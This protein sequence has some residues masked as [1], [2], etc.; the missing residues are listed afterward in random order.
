MKH[1]PGNAKESADSKRLA[2]DVRTYA[3][4]G[5]RAMFR[6]LALLSPIL[7]LILAEAGLRI[8]GTG[9]STSFF[10]TVTEHGSPRLIENSRFGWR[11][12]PANLA[13]S[14]EPLS[15]TAK[16]PANTIRIFVFGESAALGDPE[17]AYGM[18]RQLERMLQARH[19]DRTFEV[20]N[21]A[22]TAINSHVLR[23]IARDCAAVE[24]DCWVIYAGNNEVVGPFGAGTIFGKQAPAL[25]AVRLN[26]LL[27]RTRL[28]QALAAL[29]HHKGQPAEWLGMEMF[30]Q[31]QVSFSDR[32]LSR[33]YENYARNLADII[34]FG[35]RAGV[36]L[37]SA[38]MPVNLKDCPP[39]A[40]GHRL[41]LTA[42][43]QAAWDRAF[44]EGQS[45][46]R[47]AR[48]AEALGAFTRATTLDSSYAEAWFRR[49]ICEQAT[50]DVPAAEKDFK[51]ARDLDTLRFRADSE[52]N[53]IVRRTARVTQT[54]FVDAE[55]LSLTRGVVDGT[56]AATAASRGPIP[57]D[58]LF[59]DH[60]HL[61]FSGNYWLSSI[62]VPEIE[63]QVFGSVPTNAPRIDEPE[64][65]HRLAWTDFDQRRVY[66]EVRARL[67]QPPFS[68]QRNSGERQRLWD[69]RLAAVPAE[70][71]SGAE[72]YSAALKRSPGDWVLHA[73]FARLLQAGGDPVSAT[74]EWQQVT[75]LLPHEPEAFFQ[76]GNLA[77]DRGAYEEADRFFHQALARN[78]RSTESLNGLG[79]VAR[80]RGQFQEA[81]RHFESAL[82]VNPGFSMAR[83]NLGALLAS[84]G[85]TVEAKREYERVLRVDTNNVP[86][87][88][89][90]AKLLLEEGNTEESLKLYGEAV[91]LQP[92][93]A[94]AQFNLANI[95]CAR[96]RN[97]E[98]I[99]HYQAAVRADPGF[100]EARYNLG[101]ELARAGQIAEALEEFR[102]VV[103]LKPADADAHFNY[104]VALARQK[105]Y[106]D[107]V[108]EFK[109]TLKLKPQHP[110]AA[111]MLERAQM[112]AD[113][114]GLQ[115][116]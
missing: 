80:S 11:F 25:A 87:R 78:P 68:Y 81:R 100:A 72:V 93:D 22:M 9:Y 115:G 86:A 66:E 32:R 94:A 88:L 14:P 89:N 70:P 90:L 110:S 23:E 35:R 106:A 12:F 56:S 37:V 30:L 6:L 31:Q 96:R 13:R 112:L 45:A 67:Q 59:Y 44:Q 42:H 103:R 84:G 18:P 61:N 50:G 16:K 34:A 41:G 64:M 10:L 26:L 21:V 79:L 39:F 91:K 27:K 95:L 36:K 77:Q 7:L 3:T 105:L 111:G 55:A 5:R 116:K 62:L 75:N 73:R 47:E 114:P 85:N 108:S 65:K 82:A 29:G 2:T 58:D 51:K 60:V 15:L 49:A 1:R 8:A 107:A 53:E 28:G 92:G 33:V 52:L 43:D 38:T 17:P 40:S 63:R 104:G 76:L 71:K 4:P 109:E 83:I 99:P 54:G 48:Y 113:T 69:Q 101:L 97:A 102:N 19:P 24:S 20:V 57:G 98:A 46:E 74:A